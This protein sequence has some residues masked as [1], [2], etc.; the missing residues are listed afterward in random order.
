MSHKES[1]VTSLA[2]ALDTRMMNYFQLRQDLP[3]RIRLVR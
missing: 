2:N 3:K 1:D